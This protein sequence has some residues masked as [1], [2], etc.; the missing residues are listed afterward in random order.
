MASIKLLGHFVDIGSNHVKGSEPCQDAAV[1]ESVDGWCLIA[2][3]DGAGSSKLSHLGSELL[4]KKLLTALNA[5]EYGEEL[6]PLKVRAVVSNAILDF[7]Q[8]C[9]N[10]SLEQNITDFACT[11]L[12]AIISP[13]LE[14]VSFHI[15]DGAMVLIGNDACV[16]KSLPENG[17]YANETYFATSENWIEH[18]RFQDGTLSSGQML[19]AMTDGVTPFAISGATPFEEFLKPLA[20]FISGNEQKMV[21]DALKQTFSTAKA[22]EISRDDKAM[23]WFG[24]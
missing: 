16:V 14:Y 2:V 20:K 19:I 23:A 10:N 6:D 11:L 8:D 12:G 21:S 3:S 24:C 18:I 1:S 17:E 5:Q 7:R 13:R 15:G 4:L 22:L 9:A